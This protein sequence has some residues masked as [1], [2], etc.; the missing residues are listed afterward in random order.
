MTKTQWR[1]CFTMLVLQL[2]DFLSTRT[3]LASGG[4]EMN[5]LLN[6]MNFLQLGLV[7]GGSVVLFAWLVYRSRYLRLLYAACGFFTLVVLWNCLMILI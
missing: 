2:S 7:K 5:P 1:L 4:Q 6:R 3:V